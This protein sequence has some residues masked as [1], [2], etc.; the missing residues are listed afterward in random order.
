M[1]VAHDL[2]SYRVLFSFYYYPAAER[3]FPL[4]AD[5][6]SGPVKDNFMDLRGVESLLGQFGRA[7]ELPLENFLGWVGARPRAT[8][9]I[10]H[11]W[12]L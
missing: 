12:L 8:W 7:P 9:S 3:L 1:Y 10:Y 6:G 11:S 2:E 5:Y 4:F